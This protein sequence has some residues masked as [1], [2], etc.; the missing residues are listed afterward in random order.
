MLKAKEVLIRQLYRPNVEL[1]P[2]EEAAYLKSH[3]D[4]KFVRS[5][6]NIVVEIQWGITQW[7]FGFPFDFEDGWK[8]REAIVLAGASVF[9]LA[10]EIY[11]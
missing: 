5:K 7:S 1:S 3:H 6:D 4:Y 8:H 2:E 9:N 11:S 10:P